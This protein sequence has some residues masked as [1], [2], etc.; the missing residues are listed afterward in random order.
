[1]KIFVPVQ[2]VPDLVEEI[3]VAPSG[4]SLDLDYVRWTINEFDDHAVEQAVLLKERSGGSVI[5]AAP[6]L[7]GA[8]DVLYSAA[9]RGAD[10]LFRLSGDFSTETHSHAYAR[11]LAPI[12]SSEKP[13]LIL[14]G[15]QAHH[16]FDGPVGPLLAEM[17][18]LPYIGYVSRVEI[19]DGALLVDKEYPGG[20]IAR[21]QVTLPAVLGIQAA[22]T[23]PR[24]VPVA[25]VRQAM[26]TSRI[27]DASVDIDLSGGSA[28]SR[29]FTPEAAGHAEMLTGAPEEIAARIVQILSNQIH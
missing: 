22:D 16:Q 8:D 25:R 28:V 20:L 23:A 11:L 14:T 24:Y 15:V 13:D 12:I 5:V 29:M 7:E 6:D 26:K 4:N 21:I 27:D 10:C 2:L 18:G 1:M 9:A 19:G 17:L 3:V